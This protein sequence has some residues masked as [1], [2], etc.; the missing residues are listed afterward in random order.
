MS[1]A[2]P[3]ATGGLVMQRRAL[4]DGQWA[5][6]APLLPGKA[7]DPGR[8]AGDNR[9]FVEGVLWLARHAAAWRALPEEFGPW[10]SAFVRF[11]RWARAGV[12]DRVFA[13]V[14]RD[15][16]FAYAIIDGTI[17]RVHQHAN[18]GSRR[19]KRGLRVRPSGEAEAA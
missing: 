1:E 12:W 13:E 18:G 6:I 19:T 10:N 15:I 17:V 3:G 4:S 8:T 7:S 2:Y 14:S 16:D 9:L 11:N 5:R